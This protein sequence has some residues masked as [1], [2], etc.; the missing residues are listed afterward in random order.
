MATT[1]ATAVQTRTSTLTSKLKH[2]LTHAQQQRQAFSVIQNTIEYGIAQICHS[3]GVFPPSF[4]RSLDVGDS[5]SSVTGNGDRVVMFDLDHLDANADAAVD[6]SKD[7]EISSNGDNLSRGIE[8]SPLTSDF[9]EGLQSQ[10]AASTSASASAF[11]NDYDKNHNH[12]Q[13]HDRT[14]KMKMKMAIMRAEVRLLQHWM[15]GL[16]ELFLDER[17]RGLLSRVVFGIC[18]S[19]TDRDNDDDHDHDHDNGGIGGRNEKDELL[20]SYAVS[21]IDFEYIPV[22]TVQ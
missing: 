21:S 15:G 5:G 17:Q 22:C 11:T 12:G 9:E 18:T 13:D 7:S 10:S 16:H 14:V 2:K 8:L 20:E 6:A 3:R 19:G 4:F 1:T